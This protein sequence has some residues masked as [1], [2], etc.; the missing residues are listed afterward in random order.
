MQQLLILR[1]AKAVP[2]SPAAEDF[3]RKLTSAGREHAQ[4][5]A[6]W[7][8]QNLA[9]PEVILCSP[10]QRTRETL[11]PIL[12]LQPQL[13]AVVH[14]QPQLY[15]ATTSTIE[16]LLTLLCGVNRVLIVG[17]N[18][19]LKAWLRMSF[20]PITA[21]RSCSYPRVRWL[22]WIL[23]KAGHPVTTVASCATSFVARNFEAR[24]TFGTTVILR[25][26][27]AHD[28]HQSMELR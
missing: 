7:L 20:A 14:F 27:H 28:N 15:H 11:A 1:H 4:K 24:S 21:V 16:T 10:S 23:P 5:V 2:W 12:S 17:H 25:D 3:P 22:W 19:V 18:P 6:T 9:P 26:R 13:E 8:S